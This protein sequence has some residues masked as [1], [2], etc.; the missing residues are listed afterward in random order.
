MVTL[1]SHKLLYQSA[2]FCCKTSYSDV[3]KHACFK[4]KQIYLHFFK[5]DYLFAKVKVKQCLMGISRLN[6]VDR[7]RDCWKLETVNWKLTEIKLAKKLTE[8]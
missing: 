7:L 6:R 8:A 1:Y 2:L 4:I 5:F 3:Q